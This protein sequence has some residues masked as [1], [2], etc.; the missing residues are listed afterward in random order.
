[1][2]TINGPMTL[3][4]TVSLAMTSGGTAQLTLSATAPNPTCP[5]GTMFLLVWT[6]DRAACFFQDHAHA[7]KLGAGLSVIATDPR[8]MIDRGGLCVMCSV[9]DIQ[10]TKPGART[11]INS[12]PVTRWVDMEPA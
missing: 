8:P 7:L 10:I 11:A 6:G 9:V 3:C 2:I 4:D 1:M 12:R 5:N